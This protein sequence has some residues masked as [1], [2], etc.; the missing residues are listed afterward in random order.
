MA[1]APIEYTLVDDWLGYVGVNSLRV[2]SLARLIDDCAAQDTSEIKR[3]HGSARTRDKSTHC[4][5]L[6]LQT[7]SCL[8]FIRPWPIINRR[9]RHLTPKPPQSLHF[10]SAS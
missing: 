8:Q 7:Q 2:N 5:A 4:K 9:M 10:T 1:G 3:R 6:V